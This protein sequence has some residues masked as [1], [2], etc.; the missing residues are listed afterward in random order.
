MQVFGECGDY[1]QMFTSSGIRIS[2]AIEVTVWPISGAV[3]HKVS[4][5]RLLYPRW[6]ETW[7]IVIVTELSQVI[8]SMGYRDT[9]WAVPGGVTRTVSWYWL[10]SPRCTVPARVE[11]QVT[12]F[13]SGLT[14]LWNAVLVLHTSGIHCCVRSK[15]D[16]Q[17]VGNTG[18]IILMVAWSKLYIC[19]RYRSTAHMVVVI[20]VKYN[21]SFTLS[22]NEMLSLLPKKTHNT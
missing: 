20:S 15:C 21:P 1:E 13:I 16:M 6:C 12:F 4:R 17:G 19:G 5:Y 7:G 3:K 11:H 8:W 9:D 14:I 18:C 10:S 22:Q 2:L